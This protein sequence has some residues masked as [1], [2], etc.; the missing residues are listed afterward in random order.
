[1]G[2]GGRSDDGRSGGGGSGGGDSFVDI[3]TMKT[4]DVYDILMKKRRRRVT[5]EPNQT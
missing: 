1:M 4:K 5:T 2:C 3:M